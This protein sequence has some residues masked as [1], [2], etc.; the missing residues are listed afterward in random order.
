MTP[1]E[2]RGRRCPAARAG[3]GVEIEGPTQ[4]RED[5]VRRDHRAAV[6]PVIGV[7]RHLFDDAQLVALVEAEPQQCR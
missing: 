4:R 3:I 5:L 1:H 7:E 2:P 6:P